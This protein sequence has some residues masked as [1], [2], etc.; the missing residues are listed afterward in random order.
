[1]NLRH[2]INEFIRIN[3]HPKLNSVLVYKDGDI[4]AEN[5]YNG[6]NESSRNIIKSVAKSIMSVCTGIALDKGFIQSLDEPIGKYIPEF[7]GSNDPFH[8]MITIRHLLTMTSGIHFSGGVHYHCPM[9]EQ[10]KR[11]GNWIEHIADTMIKDMAGTKYCYKEWDVILLASVIENAVGMDMFDFLNENL[12]IPLG[13]KSDRWWKSKCG[14][15]YSVANGDSGKEEQQS[16]LSARDMLKIGLLFMNDGIYDGKQIVSAEY[17]K[18]AITPSK[19]NSG[20]GL[21]WWLG[22]NW[23]GCR[24]YAGQSITVVPDK[25]AVVVTQGAQNSSGRGYDDVIWHCFSLI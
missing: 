22:D 4:I 1:M 16:S 17:V 20:Y 13:I 21:L 24:G 14:A 5:Y 23:Y 12:Y 3:H 19:C 10:M 9:F 6:F 7:D 25:K 15:T 18:S 2:E 8:K 11:S